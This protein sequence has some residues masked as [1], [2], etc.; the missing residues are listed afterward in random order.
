MMLTLGLWASLATAQAGEVVD[1]IAAVVD[2]EVIAL[3]EVYELGAEFVASRCPTQQA[4][5]QQE[6]E[7]EILDELI[8]RA[9]VK[10]ELR[11]LELA[12]TAADVDQ[13]IDQAVRDNGFADREALRAEVERSGTTWQVYRDQIREIQMVQRFQQVVLLPRVSVADEELQDFYQRTLRDMKGELEVDI[14]AF[15]MMLPTD[16]SDEGVIGLIEQLT[17]VVEAIR[18]GEKEW[19]EASNENDQAALA[20]AIG[21]RAYRAG[22]LA[23]PL[24]SLAFAEE[25]GGVVGPV[26]VGSVLAVMRVNSREERNRD[27][28]PFDEI[29]DQLHG[30]LMQQKMGEAES[31]WYQRIRRQSAVEVMLS[32]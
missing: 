9:L 21:G 10:Q 22:E 31:E 30:Q 13:Y 7:L 23:G 17:S 32:N 5:C 3:S 12:V 4:S 15:G 24:D 6:A 2:D 28:K 20:S 8:K 1:R 19:D 29:K 16:A 11:R 18:A 25:I 26:R 14:D 27:V